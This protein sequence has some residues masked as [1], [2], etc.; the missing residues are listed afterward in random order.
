MIRWQNTKNNQQSVTRGH[1]FT[2]FLSK[3]IILKIKPTDLY[4]FYL[5]F[6]FF[7]S[8]TKLLSRLI[9]KGN[10]G[11]LLLPLKIQNQNLENIYFS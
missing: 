3:K 7:S 9:M 10:C 1:Y 6:V 2:I 5:I 4:N 8:V 11:I